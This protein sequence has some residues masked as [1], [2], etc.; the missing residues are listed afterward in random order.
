MCSHGIGRLRVTTILC[1]LVVLFL[2]ML[3]CRDNGVSSASPISLS[4]PTSNFSAPRVAVPTLTVTPS[5]TLGTDAIALCRPV[6]AG[7]I[8]GHVTQAGKSVPDGVYVGMNLNGGP[9][10]S[11]QVSNGIYKM[12]LLARDCPD[13][14]HWVDFSLWVGHFARAIQPNKPEMQ[15]DIDLPRSEQ[16][17]I[18]SVP[19]CVL[20]FGR[21]EGKVRLNGVPAADG[22]PIVAARV[23]KGTR[24]PLADPDLDQVTQKAFTKDGK[25]MVTSIGTVCDDDTKSYL[26][27]TLFVPGASIVVTPTQE[28]HVQDIIAP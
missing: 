13:G 12:P 20:D 3:G 27:F 14:I 21:V 18:T 6:Q 4:T 22:T 16:I 11:S 24:F 2:S 7:T 25:Y 9:H 1:F 17:V 23:G 19:M 10:P 15:I 26:S 8:T 28:I 5:L